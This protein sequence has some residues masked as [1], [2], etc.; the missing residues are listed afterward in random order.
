MTTRTIRRRPI[1]IVL[2]AF[3]VLASTPVLAA[4]NSTSP[5]GHYDLDNGHSKFKKRK[6]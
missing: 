6:H 4:C 3:A 2:T 5:S 1:V